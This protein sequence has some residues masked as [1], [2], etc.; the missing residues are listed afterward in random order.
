[1]SSIT[2][3]EN[4]TA[5]RGISRETQYRLFLAALFVLD[6]LT[7]VAAFTLAYVVR[8]QTNWAF[9]VED[10]DAGRGA[11]IAIAGVLLPLWLLIFVL[12]E[13]YNP[14]YLFSSTQEYKKVF[15]ACSVAFTFVVVGTF[16]VP[17]VRVSRGWIVVAWLAAI[18]LVIA[19]RFA[20][21]R[22]S[23]FLREHHWL[24]ARTLIVGTD[25]EA[26]AIARQ[27][28][29]W[30]GCG[31]D[32]VGFVDDFL[33]PGAKVEE[34]VTVVGPL[35]ALPGL[36]QQLDVDELIV[37]PSAISREDILWIFQN[38][39]TSNRVEL[40]FSPG[41]FEIFTSGVRV[42]EIGAVP[43]VSMRKVRLDAIEATI[44][45]ISDY[46]I[47]IVALVL[48]SPLFL[49]VALAI[50]LDSPGPI[51]YR[52]RVLGQGGKEFYALKFRT[53][54]VNGDEILAKYPDLKAE[55]A[56]N[57]KLKNDPRVTRIGQLLRKYSIDELPQLFNVLAGQMSIVGPRMITPTEAEK[58]GKWRWNLLTVKPGITG[59][60][61]ISGRSDVS[62]ADRIRL[63]MYYIR[64]YT[65]WADLRIIW[66]T[67][68]VVL[69]GKG[70]Y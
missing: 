63:D 40:R 3:V 47:A 67:I 51:L 8:F 48:L 62:Y 42:K 25:D 26:R 21:R 53:M 20:M 66:R 18:I 35:N 49:V 31:A 57:E 60:W 7:L 43:L 6:T 13:L 23:Y 55:L 46:L 65:V 70:A 24:I 29:S 10:G 56:H 15:N 52:R 33:P 27:L 36:I 14:H 44:K 5:Y 38:F 30:H 28:L 12:S 17:L 59:L 54:Y 69:G 34:G 1:M 2:Q 68:P 4:L 50:K 37:S 64:N 11:H 61:Q 32:V 9:L 58:Y 41:L 45:T 16:L 39:G 19:G 22:V